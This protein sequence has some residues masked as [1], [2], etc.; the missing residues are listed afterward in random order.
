MFLDAN[1]SISGNRRENRKTIPPPNHHF[2]NKNL[3]Y[4]DVLKKVIT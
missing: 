2:G 1:H 4:I 3:L